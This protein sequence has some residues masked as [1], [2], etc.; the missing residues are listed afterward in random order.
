MKI[1]YLIIGI[2]AVAILIAGCSQETTNTNQTNMTNKTNETVR[3]AN[4]ASVFCEDSG[5][6]LDIRDETGGQVGYCMFEDGSECEEWA[7]FRGECKPASEENKTNLLEGCTSYYDGCNTCF[8]ENSSLTACTKMYCK[9]PSEPKC[10]KYT[11][12]QTAC[13]KNSG[14]WLD[15]FNECEGISQQTCEANDG[16]FN[17]CASACRHNPKAEACTMQCVPVCN[18]ATE[19]SQ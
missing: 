11:D 10:L 9:N 7:Y 3:I 13:E 16:I 8:V 2:L 6:T 15:E 4:P 12:L 17:E 5:G 19:V 14:K 18:A 1:Q